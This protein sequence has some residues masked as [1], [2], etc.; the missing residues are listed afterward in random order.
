MFK[1]K[2]KKTLDYGSRGYKFESCRG[3]ELF[4]KGSL[5]YLLDNTQSHRIIMVTVNG[6]QITKTA[7]LNDNDYEG[8]A[9]DVVKITPPSEINFKFY[10]KD[11][12]YNIGQIIEQVTV[13]FYQDRYEIR[14]VYG[15][16][17]EKSFIKKY[18]TY[19]NPTEMIELRDLISN[20][21]LRKVS[22][23]I[24]KLLQ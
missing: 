8:F 12:I 16:Q 3:F 10:L 4:V 2:F 7:L 21:I 22:A 19:I 11:S 18:M 9:A 20:N 1:F 13:Y 14:Y 5:Q 6:E 24:N 15:A 23:K 17:I